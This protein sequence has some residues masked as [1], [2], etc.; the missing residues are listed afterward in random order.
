MCE[1]GQGPGVAAA[2]SRINPR[3]IP[4]PRQQPRRKPHGEREASPFPTLA[5]LPLRIGIY[6]S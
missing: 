4:I 2:N 6:L 3:F 1:G 5:S